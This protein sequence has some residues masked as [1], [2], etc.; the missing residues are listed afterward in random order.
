MSLVKSKIYVYW[1]PNPSDNVTPFHFESRAQ[2]RT[3]LA[4]WDCVSEYQAQ[5]E[6][7]APQMVERY[8]N[9]YP[10]GYELIW[11]GPRNMAALRPEGQTIKGSADVIRAVLDHEF[12]RALAA[13]SAR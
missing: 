13:S 5:T 9:H 3:V 12:R 1:V 4:Q 2:D 11:A 6:M 8:R 10:N 7:M